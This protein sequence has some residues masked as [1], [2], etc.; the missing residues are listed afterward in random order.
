MVIHFLLTTWLMYLLDAQQFPDDL[1]HQWNVRT[2]DYISFDNISFPALDLGDLKK[3]LQ[4][5]NVE[6]QSDCMTKLTSLITN[7]G[8]SDPAKALE[9]LYFVDAAGKPSSGLMTANSFMIG[10]YDQCQ[11]MKNS[12]AGYYDS[13]TVTANAKLGNVYPI[14]ITWT[15]CLPLECRSGDASDVQTELYSL[16]NKYLGAAVYLI[17]GQATRTCATPMMWD[18]GAFVAATFMA[19]FAVLVVVGTLWYCAEPIINSLTKPPTEDTKVLVENEQVENVYEEIGPRNKAS[20]IAGS[21]FNPASD[22]LTHDSPCLARTGRFFKC[23]ALQRTLA[24]LTCTDTKPGQ[25]LCLNGIRVLSIN[26][27]VLG[28]IYMTFSFFNA[29]PSYGLKLMKRWDF[30]F[31]LNGLPSVDSFFTLSGFLVAYLL[32]KQLSNGMNFQKWIAYYVHRYFRLTIPYAM[33]I[34]LEGFMYRVWVT[35]PFISNIEQ[36]HSNCKDYWWAN[37]L[38]VNNFV[39]KIAGE[40][41]IGQSWYLANDMQFFVVAPIFIILLFKNSLAGLIANISTIV[42]SMVTAAA[43]TY[44]YKLGPSTVADID[45]TKDFYTVY[46]KPYVRITPYI[47][48]IL[49]G[50]IY[51][52]Y[53]QKL[54][55]IVSRLS[56]WKQVLIGSPIWLVTAAI[57][58]AIV[59]GLYDDL[60][61]AV[62]EHK[63]PDM[64]DSISYQMLARI[65]WGISLTIQIL[66]CQCGLGGFINS[67]LSWK[68]WIVLSRLTYSVYLLHLGLLNM[69]SYQTRHAFFVQPDYQM[70]VMYLG[71]LLMSY[72][73]ATV[74]YVT[75]EQP[76]ALIET[77]AYR[78]PKTDQANK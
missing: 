44:Y 28:H 16:I 34:L 10:D 39:P 26:W 12:S 73:A 60:Q 71:I 2:F 49:G 29:T 53:G 21:E 23:F 11:T 41:C 43:L 42:A 63:N 4:V 30:G 65:G 51:W 56:L 75:V 48:G 77:L 22:E 9:S 69:M 40:V 8:S 31:V 13:C 70:A 62:I 76:V 36:P 72:L 54:K 18:T 27:V 7:F 25:I 66:V 37:I 46:N 61:L 57:Q 24:I 5:T 45:V 20:L 55:S 15:G 58:Y 1:R 35:G 50:W 38:Y 78:K 52:K 64:V 33:V 32:L 14:T 68:G 74:L 47:I 3:F 6:M 19:L 17:P 59:F 67:L